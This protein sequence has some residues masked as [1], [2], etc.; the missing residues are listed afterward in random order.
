MVIILFPGPRAQGRREDP[1]TTLTSSCPTDRPCRKDQSGEGADALPTPA[2]LMSRPGHI[3]SP[4]L[5]CQGPQL[6]QER[7]TGVV[8]L[9][10]M[11][12]WVRSREI[13]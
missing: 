3:P 10:P 1:Q 6:S 5:D 13:K 4:K 8:C 9:V 12:Q 2:H 7:T 11:F